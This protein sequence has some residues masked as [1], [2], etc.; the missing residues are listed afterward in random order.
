M[1]FSQVLKQAKKELQKFSSPEKARNS[2]RFFKTGKGQYGEGDKFIGVT[3]PEQR[4]V[5][6]YIVKHFFESPATSLVTEFDTLLK[7]KE[8]E[9]RCTALIALTYI[10]ERLDKTNE[11]KEICK[12]IYEYYISRL[13]YINNWD[14]V[15]TSAREIV[16]AYLYKTKT[17]KQGLGILNNMTI[18]TNIWERRVAIV[19]T[20]Y[21]IM[22]GRFTQ[23]IRISEKLLKDTHDL[24][25]KAVGWMLREMGKKDEPTLLAFLDIHA[26]AM[27][28]T[29]LRYSIERL[30]PELRVKYM[31]R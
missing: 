1:K 20:H 16:G 24:I 26:K 28:R 29:A 10:Y 3:V 2:Q 17:E 22:K 7:A 4:I 15:D 12:T 6:L 14:L 13:A 5:A 18:S 21:F 23:T 19:S 25:H 27:P 11:M 31:L 30:V 8:H 9:Y